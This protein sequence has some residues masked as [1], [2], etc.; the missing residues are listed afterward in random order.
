MPPFYKL[1]TTLKACQKSGVII[2]LKLNGAVTLSK[3]MYSHS[4]VLDLSFSLVFRLSVPC[5]TSQSMAGCLSARRG[6]CSSTFAVIVLNV[7]FIISFV[8]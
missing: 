4:P 2:Y 8:L 5:E 7:F 6:L 3:G 1:G